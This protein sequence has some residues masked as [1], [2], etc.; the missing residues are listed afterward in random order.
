MD[1]VKDYQ[2]IRITIHDNRGVC[3]H[4]EECIKAM[5]S[6][7]RKG[8]RPWIDPDSADNQSIIDAIR[9]CPSGALSYSV[10][11]VHYDQINSD[12]GI[13]AAK[14]GPYEIRGKVELIDDQDSRP[15]CADHYVLCRCNASQNKPFCDG[16]HNDVG[17][18]G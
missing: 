3:S 5:P 4:S 11:G 6:V 1:K 14:N 16:S 18:E 15:R 12:P 9:K 17:F 13:I 8:G 10:N 7:F 2:G